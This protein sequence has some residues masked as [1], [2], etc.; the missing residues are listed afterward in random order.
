MKLY[1]KL[2]VILRDRWRSLK[3]IA[4]LLGALLAVTIPNSISPLAIAQ[5][6]F[7]EI[8]GVWMTNNDTRGCTSTQSI[9]SSGIL[10]TLSMIAT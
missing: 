10:D 9:P 1:L 6:P 4:L 2:Y 3:Y 8:R 7:E 5:Q